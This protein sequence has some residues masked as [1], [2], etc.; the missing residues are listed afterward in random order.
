MKCQEVVS[1][2]AAYVDEELEPTLAEKISAHISRCPSC[3]EELRAFSGIDTMLRNLPRDSLPAAVAARVLGAA[4]GTEYH[5]APS[6]FFRT[7]WSTI[8]D[9][10]EQLFDLLQTESAPRTKSLEE[11]NDVPSSFIGHAYFRIIGC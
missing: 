5:R 1:R 11:F 6:G 4:G 8:F 2:M 9:R 10:L 3:K 7:V